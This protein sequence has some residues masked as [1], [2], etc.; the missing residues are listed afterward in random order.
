[1]QTLSYGSK[2]PQTGDGGAIFWPALEDNISLSDGHTHN[3]S[4]SPLLTSA[5][6][7]SVKVTAP[8]AAWVHVGGGTYRQAVDMPAGM[9]FDDYSITVKDS[10]GNILYLTVEQITTTSFYVYIN[11]N[12]LT[13]TIL[14]VA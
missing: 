3:G 10:S 11:D 8:S 6:I 5:S 12:T 13:L 7:V 14:L 9:T 1:M 4:N 2:K